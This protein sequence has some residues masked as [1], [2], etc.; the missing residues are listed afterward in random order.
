MIFTENVLKHWQRWF[1]R[2]QIAK[3]ERDG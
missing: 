1:E 3:E 2:I